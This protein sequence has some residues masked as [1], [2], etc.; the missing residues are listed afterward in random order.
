MLAQT[1]LVHQR[2]LPNFPQNLAPV[3]VEPQSAV[4]TSWGLAPQYAPASVQ[5][6]PQQEGRSFGTFLAGVVTVVGGVIMFDPK[7]S[8]EEKAIAQMAL[9]ASVPFLLNKAFE[10]QVPIPQ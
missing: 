4:P 3:F 7:A 1:N 9:G 6:V 10:L 8:K 2:Q 5:I